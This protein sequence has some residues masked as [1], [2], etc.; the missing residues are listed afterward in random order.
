MVEPSGSAGAD[1]DSEL[2]HLV[3]CG[4][5]D[6]LL[7]RAALMPGHVSRC[8]RCRET[9]ARGRRD[10][11]DRSLALALG[12]L[13]CLVIAHSSPLLHLSI[14]GRSHASTIAD[15]ARSLAAEGRVPLALFVFAASVVLPLIRLAGLVAILVP[16]RLGHHPAFV[17]VAYRRL[18]QLA[19]WAMLEVYL[20]GLLVAF[21][22]L[23]DLAH[24]AP[25][26]AFYGFVALIALAAATSS[27]LDPSVVFRKSVNHT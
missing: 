9:L 2:A 22:K 17:P 20:L 4:S 14:E 24:V 19:P 12:G 13:V 21:V 25:G 8:P 3:A 15:G 11:I 23:E 1:Q 18:E 27:A 6:L 16:L 5:C 10:P 7:Q 26:T